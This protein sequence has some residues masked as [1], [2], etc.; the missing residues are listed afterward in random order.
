MKTIKVK[1]ASEDK[2]NPRTNFIA[3]KFHDVRELFKRGD[4]SFKSCQTDKNISDI[5]T[6]PLTK[7]KFEY[8]RGELGLNQDY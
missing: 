2:I 8:F 1:L 6:K 5:M 4:V 7:I 3:V